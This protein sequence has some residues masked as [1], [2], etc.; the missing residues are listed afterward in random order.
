MTP[1]KAIFIF[2]ILAAALISVVG[3]LSYEVDA[4]CFYHC[5][6]V[7]LE[8]RSLNNYYQSAQRILSHPEAE[9]IIVGSSRGQTMPTHYFDEHFGLK[10]LNLSVEGAELVT[11]AALIIMALQKAPIKRVIWLAD[12][13]ELIPSGLNS[14]LINC[15]ALMA[16]VPDEMKSLINKQRTNLIESLLDHNNFEATITYLNKKPPIGD[17]WGSGSGLDAK[18][19]A[20]AGYHGGVTEAVL[21]KKV[22]IMYENY[23]QEILRPPQSEA[24]EELFKKEMSELVAKGLEVAVVIAPY[25]PRFMRQLKA[26]FPDIYNKHEQWAHRLE[27]LTGPHLQVINGWNGIPNGDSTPRSWND[28]VHYTCQSAI[29]LINQIKR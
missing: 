16:K 5:S 28:G 29:A 4:M 20:N 13:F 17:D 1:L 2:G 15:P 23:T 7:S 24:A 19:C 27:A 21:E 25:Q 12:Y 22:D 6:S 3:G 10:T 8:R 26:E 14:K 9:Q 11:K 18:E